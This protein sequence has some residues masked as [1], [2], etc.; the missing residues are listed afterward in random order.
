MGPLSVFT[1]IFSEPSS[2]PLQYPGRCLRKRL[3]TNQCQ[4]CVRSCPSGAVTL[5]DREIVFVE[6]KCT[7]CMACTAV[8]P[9]DALESEYDIKELVHLCK[10]DADIVIT[11]IRQKQSGP[12]EIILPCIGILSKQVLSA[13][14]LKNSKSVIINVAGCAKCCNQKVS[15]NFVNEYKLLAEVF[16]K[17]KTSKI[18]L[19][20]NDQQLHDIIVDRRL[21]LT[22]IKKF[23]TTVTKKSITTNR[24]TLPEKKE[25]TRRIPV[26]V[27]LL[28]NLV[29]ELETE[30]R[31]KIF[32]LFCKQ[33][34]INDECTFC[35]LCKGI[36]PTG[37][38]QIERSE[39]GKKIKF[40]PLD[41]SCCGLC[42]E[43]C[44][45][46]ALSIY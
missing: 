6:E 22:N 33:L 30:S 34:S 28:K 2:Y 36:C 5:N 21:Y 23:A 40:N 46:N 17:V 3:N 13:I 45:K 27:R 16:V 9:Q 38:I 35:P 24:T 26:K 7:G 43:F 37:A 25:T 12:D 8:C 11:C 31:K 41:C 39:G 14:F 44:K 4:R 10:G 20:Y 1:N 19:N 18:S 42:V 29:A 32:E 15:D